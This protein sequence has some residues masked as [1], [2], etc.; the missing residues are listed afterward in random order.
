MSTVANSYRTKVRLV[1]DADLVARIKREAAE[2]GLPV[3]RYVEDV[4]A[5]VLPQM[6]A[7][8][9]ATYI[10]QSRRLAARAETAEE[11]RSP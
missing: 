3:E 7:E 6:V 1:L 2:R 11:A 9:S 10:E 4:L 8:A 5:G